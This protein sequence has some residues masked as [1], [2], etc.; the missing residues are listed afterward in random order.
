MPPD[1]FAKT[2]KTT[3]FEQRVFSL[4]KKIPK[5]RV[6]AYK[7][8]AEKLGGKSRKAYRAVGNALN[9]NHY[10]NVPCH[11]VVKSNGNIGGFNKGAKIKALLLKREGIKVKHGKVVNFSK[12]LHRFK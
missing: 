7:I 6:S 2:M 1:I 3:E 10:K 9:K 11:R 8:L 5:G 12:M 4:A